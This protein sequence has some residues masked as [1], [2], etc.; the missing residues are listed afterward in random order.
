MGKFDLLVAAIRDEG[1][2]FL[3]DLHDAEDKKIFDTV[4]VIR[5]S[6]SSLPAVCIGEFRCARTTVTA[7]VHPV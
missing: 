7:R 6:P 5:F 2:L 4:I 3:A 1:M